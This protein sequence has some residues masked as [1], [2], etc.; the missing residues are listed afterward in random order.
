M[1]FVVGLFEDILH[2]RTTLDR[3]HEVGFTEDKI[4]I[5]SREHLTKR[6]SMDIYNK[7][8]SDIATIV[9]GLGGVF[10][11]AAIAF[12]VVTMPSLG[13]VIASGVFGPVL[14][15]TIGGAVGAAVGAYAGMKLLPGLMERLQI[16]EQDAHFF[17]EAVK[18]DGILVAVETTADNR[19][20]VE[21]IMKDSSAV[22]VR[23]RRQRYELE[24]WREYIENKSAQGDQR[25]TP[26]HSDPQI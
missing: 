25:M 5:L 16:S 10:A 22:D 18:R 21:E 3:L 19:S 1:A 7:R 6:D 23:E 24:G 15:T 20:Q 9:G 8:T 14:A 2:V 11:G 12:A 17:A 13:L 4:S 26:V